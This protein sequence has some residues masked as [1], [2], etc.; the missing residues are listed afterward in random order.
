MKKW[1][2]I[3]LANMA[4]VAIPSSA[5]AETPLSSNEDFGPKWDELAEYQGFVAQNMDSW[6]KGFDRVEIVLFNYKEDEARRLVEDGSL[7][8]GVIREYTKRLSNEE[9]SLL[10][11]IVTG[12]HP[13]R[14]GGF[15]GFRPHHGFIF[16][17][18][19]DKVLG[20]LEICFLCSDY[21]SRPWEGLSSN[22]DLNGLRTLVTSL[23]LPI[24]KDDEDWD[25]FFAS[26]QKKQK[27]N[28][29]ALDNP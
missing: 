15:C 17:G 4:L 28:K 2:S 16:Y 6:I 25:K 22:W 29:P 14:G 7:H 5:I 21:L 3:L 10:S 23:G 27:S 24:L 12:K 13:S 19:D 11:K 8:K 1:W 20:H 26:N 18:K 9:V